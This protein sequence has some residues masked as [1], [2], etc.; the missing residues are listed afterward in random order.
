VPTIPADSTH[1]HAKGQ[2]TDVMRVIGTLNEKGRKISTASYSNR[3]KISLELGLHL[4]TLN[5]LKPKLV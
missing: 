4:A 1:K 5:P 2:R 3:E